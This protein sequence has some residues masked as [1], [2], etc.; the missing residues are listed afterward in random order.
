[1][2]QDNGYAFVE[3]H[4]QMHYSRMGHTTTD[5]GLA[6]TGIMGL[7]VGQGL[8]RGNT[9]IPVKGDYLISLGVRST[10]TASLD[11]GSIKTGSI[12]ARGH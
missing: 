5:R 12:T 3:V 9:T 7:V 10:T 2:A 6:T 1:M 11:G 4:C 8:G